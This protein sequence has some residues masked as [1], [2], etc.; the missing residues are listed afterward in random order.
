MIQELIAWLKKNK[1][2]FSEIDNEVIEIIGFGKV[3]IEDTSKINSIFRTDKEGNI[4]F[5]SSEDMESL[6]AENIYY[7]VFKFGDNW[8]YFDIRQGFALN[9]LKYVGQRTPPE[10]EVQFVN[11]GV[12][13]PFELLNGSFMPHLWV[14]KALYCGHQA[15]GI[16]DRNT[17]AAYYAFQ[18]ECK[19]AGIKHIFGY[20][21]TFIDKDENK[22]GA[23]VY[24]QTQVGL[25]NLLRIQKAIMVD[26][27]DNII[28]Y[29]ELLNRAAGNVL[30]LDKYSS[31]WI[32]Q[33]PD[34]VSELLNAFEHVFYQ[35]DLSEYKAERIDIKVLQA[36]K[37]YFDNLYNVSKVHPILLCDCYYLDKDDAKNKVILNKIAEG[38]A[39]EQSDE[40]Y[41][42][43]VDEHYEV[44]KQLFNPEKWNVEILFKECCANTMVIANGAVASFDNTKNYMP[45]YDMLPEEKLKY[46][47]THNM[48]N[49]LLE[50]GLQRLIPAHKQNEYRKQM[51]YEKYIIES[52]NNVDYLLVQYDTCNWARQN[53]ILVGC[54]RGS[55]AGSLLLY[56][57]GITLI[58]PLQYGLIF[59]RFLLPERAGLYKTNTTIIGEDIESNEYVTL[60]LDGG[61]NIKIYKDAELL[62]KR[63]GF[64]EPII[65]YADELLP[66]DD[67]LFDNKDALFTINEI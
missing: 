30:V 35:V 62:I 54:G 13:T 23:K 51:E 60:E 67:I 29:E 32:Q 27:P 15:I 50:E 34:T 46:G 56:L 7:T 33:N 42:K 55:A 48:F 2:T 26:S 37:H 6:I 64:E 14:Q 21:L 45:K 25:R 5:N 24:V 3:F 22:V 38:A 49:Q 43:D 39:H 31:Y 1:I 18:K 40:Q 47:T 57:L 41:Y 16:C 9:I 53:G 66:D 10:M 63:S 12:H 65:V 28:Q 20:S 19:N 11:L 52:T 4:V 44:F 59:E 58:D 61:H 36:T 17:M 8:Y